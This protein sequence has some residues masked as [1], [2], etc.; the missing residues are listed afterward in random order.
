MLKLEIKS[1]ALLFRNKYWH[2]SSL[3]KWTKNQKWFIRVC[4]SCDSETQAIE[5]MEGCP[6]CQRIVPK[7]GYTK[8]SPS[9]C[10]FLS[11]KY[12]HFTVTTNN[13]DFEWLYLHRMI[14]ALSNSYSLSSYIT[15]LCV[16]SKQH[17]SYMYNFL[18]LLDFF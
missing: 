18:C 11:S 7:S 2:I 5:R 10:L 16:C 13:V 14:L 6:I 15:I 1:N 9:L 4:T 3:Y 8:I 17:Y 12:K